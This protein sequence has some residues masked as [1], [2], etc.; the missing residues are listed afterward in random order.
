VA[1][2][3]GDVTV[4][5]GGGRNERVWE[6]AGRNRRVRARASEVSVRSGRLN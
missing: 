1:R 4:Q 2:G 3:C 6:W 5:E